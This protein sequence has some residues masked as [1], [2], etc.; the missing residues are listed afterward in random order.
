MTK[1]ARLVDLGADIDEPDEHLRNF[2]G[3]RQSL[4]VGPEE[5]PGSLNPGLWR[6]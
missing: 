1:A 3:P 5:T 2:P 6:Y 4:G